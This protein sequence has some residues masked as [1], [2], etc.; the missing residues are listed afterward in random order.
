M[1]LAAT[2]RGVCFLGFAE[3]AEAL[4]RELRRRFPRARLEPGAEAL[5]GWLSAALAF[6]EAPRDALRLPLDLQGTA[7][8]CRV[9]EA[10]QAIPF[11]ETRSYAE[12]AAAIGAPRAARAVGRA[13]ALNPVSLVV[14]CHR[15]QGGDGALRG[16]R[17][18]LDQ[19]RALLAMERAAREGTVMPGARS[20]GRRSA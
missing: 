10:M 14:P 5:A 6:L 12:I 15:M 9:W 2:D 20:S 17:W 16:Y 3:P 1:L 18:G 19:K 4:K 8:Q 7:F 13:S 11:G